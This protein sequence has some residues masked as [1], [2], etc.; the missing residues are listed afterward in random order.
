M[1][2]SLYLM[3]ASGC[4]CVCDYCYCPAGGGRRGD[5]ALFRNIAES[6]TRHAR[7]SEFPVRPQIRFTGGEPW[8]A[9]ETLLDITELF[10]RQVHYGWIVI[11]SNATVIPAERLRDF[12]GEKRLI[13][14]I[15][16]DGPESIHDSRRRMADGRGSFNEVIKNIKVLMDMNLPVY[17]NA[18]LDTGT[19]E[20]LSELMRFIS[21]E[22]GFNELSVSLLYADHD[23]MSPEMRYDLLENAY[24]A[25]YSNSIR[26]G[27][28]HRLLPGPWIPELRCNAGISTALINPE[29]KVFACQRFVGRV[30]PDRM[31]TE[32]FDW[33]GFSSGQRCD[34]VCG[35]ETDLYVGRKLFE[36]Y[37]KMYPEYLHCNELDR[38]LFGVLP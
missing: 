28:H 27:G 10:L 12:S 36:L 26:I 14:V 30:K 19:S 18:V 8:L 2:T 7:D 23:P 13:H 6:F 16:L 25:A 15:S 31:W 29:G 22:F 38:I 5:P 35:G 9:D 32:D 20:K 17:L 11:N 4:N 34:S 33:N 24:S 3:P 37:G 1:V 21:S